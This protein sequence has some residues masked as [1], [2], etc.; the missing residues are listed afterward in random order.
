MMSDSVDVAITTVTSIL[1]VGGVAGN[2]LVCAVVVR[3]A[4]MR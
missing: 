2:S 4:E 3:H 1:I